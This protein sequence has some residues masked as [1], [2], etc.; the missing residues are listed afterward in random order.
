[1]IG[2]WFEETCTILEFKPIFAGNLGFDIKLDYIANDI[3]WGEYGI[4]FSKWVV[5]WQWGNNTYPI[6]WKRIKIKFKRL[7]RNK[8]C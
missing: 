4:S 1:M 8:K 5:W 7:W 3:Y 6:D 2:V